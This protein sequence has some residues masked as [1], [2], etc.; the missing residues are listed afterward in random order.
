MA[1]CRSRSPKPW[2]PACRGC[3]RSRSPARA[4]SNVRDTAPAQ[5]DRGG[6]PGRPGPDDHDRGAHRVRS[7]SSAASSAPQKNPWQRPIPARAAAQAVEIGVGATGEPRASRTSS[8][9]TR[10]QKQTIRPYSGSFSIAAS[11][12]NGA[13]E[14][15]ADVRH[16]R[17]RRL[18]RARL[19]PQ[20]RL[21]ELL[22]HVLGD[23]HRGREPRRA[24]SAGTGV[25]LVGVDRHLVVHMLG[26]SA[27]AH[28]DGRDLVLEQPRH[29]ARPRPAGEAGGRSSSC[30]P[31][32][33]HPRQ[34]AR[35]SR[36]RTR[37]GRSARPS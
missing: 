28:V 29:D 21:A 15:L 26:R 24:N 3:R 14:C 9:V 35:A 12:A 5:L 11:S 7:A 4:S 6:E 34:L 1:R 17:L 36:S 25:A 30:R 23:R 37:S 20:A 18:G 31:C 16:P 8:R 2:W 32:A 22:S 27:Q 19:E 10:S 13:G 33:R